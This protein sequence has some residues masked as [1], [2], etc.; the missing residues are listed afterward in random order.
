VKYVLPPAVLQVLPPV[1][2]QW[3]AALR[4]AAPDA[5]WQAAP[6]RAEQVLEL[7]ARVTPQVLPR[8]LREPR[9]S[10]VAALPAP[11]RLPQLESAEA[12][13]VRTPPREAGQSC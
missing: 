6:P 7:R 12:V 3:T 11:V 13:Q 2:L 9:S 5:P 4:Q 1:P 10:A 8:A